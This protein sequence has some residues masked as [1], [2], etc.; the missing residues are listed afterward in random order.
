MHTAIVTR[1]AELNAINALANSGKLKLY[2][3]AMPATPETAVS[4]TL[5]ATLTMNATA[6]G[7][8]SAGAAAAGAI[9][10]DTNAAASGTVGYARL[11]KSDGTTAL[12]DLT[13]GLSAADLIF[14]SLTVTAGSTVSV[15]AL[16]ITL[17]T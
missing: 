14:D 11:M 7:A 5:L 12:M 16:T 9:T 17:P 10:S 3:G 15:S 1:N 8:A 2:T 4:G 13:V 6:F